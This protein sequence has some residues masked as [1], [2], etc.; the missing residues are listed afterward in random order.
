MIAYFVGIFWEWRMR[1]WWGRFDADNRFPH[2]HDFGDDQQGMVG[3]GQCPICGEL[4]NTR[5]DAQ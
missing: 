2:I 1:H 3:A 4:V 5:E